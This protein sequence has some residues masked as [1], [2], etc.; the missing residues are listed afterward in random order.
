LVFKDGMEFLKL[1]QGDMVGYL[2]S[3]VQDFNQ[4]LTMVPMKEE[5]A[6]K[7]IFL[8]GLKPWV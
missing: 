6:K 7:L 8:H 2:V 5:Y 1:A 3:H 4:I